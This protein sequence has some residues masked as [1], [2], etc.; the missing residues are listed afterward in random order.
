M[1]Y[2][3]IINKTLIELNYAPVSAFVNLTKMEH[4]KLM[5]IINRLNKEICNMNDKFYFRQVIKNITLYPER[6]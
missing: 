4:K 5:N 3:E 2:F 1:N 6:I